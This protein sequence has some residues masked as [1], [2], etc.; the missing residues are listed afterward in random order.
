GPD[1]AAALGR[2]DRALAELRVVGPTTNAPWL[3]ALLARPEVRAGELDTTLI[4]RL[5]D[6]VAVPV[7]AAD[8]PSLAVAALLGSPASDDPWDSLDGW[9]LGGVRAPARMRLSGPDGEVS[10][11]ALPGARRLPGGLGVVGDG[12]VARFV[13]VHPDG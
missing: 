12:G 13:E 8:L 2:L 7:A 1:R 9:R 5:G 11:D 4:E 6:E 10:A 3:R